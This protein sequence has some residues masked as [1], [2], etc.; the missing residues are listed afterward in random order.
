MESDKKKNYKVSKTMLLISFT[1]STLQFL[2]ECFFLILFCLFE[3]DGEK[4]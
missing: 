3:N 4:I 2:F 1:T